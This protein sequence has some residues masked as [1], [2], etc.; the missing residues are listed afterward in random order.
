MKNKKK[1]SLF[2]LFLGILFIPLPSF[3][4]DV[5]VDEKLS[6]PPMINEEINIHGKIYEFLTNDPIQRLS[7]PFENGKVQ[8]FLIFLAGLAG[9]SIFVWYF[10]RFI[11][12]RDLLPGLL[13]RER[14]NKEN[15]ISLLILSISYAISFPIITFVWFTLYSALIFFLSSDMPYNLIMFV[16]MALIG[17]IRITSYFKEELAKDVGKAIPFS[18][19]GI[20]LTQG[21]LFTNPNFV[22]LDAIHAVL[23]EFQNKIPEIIVAVLVISV[24]EAMLRA[25]Y[26]ATFY[27]RGHHK[28]NLEGDKMMEKTWTE[29]HIKTDP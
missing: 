2:L 20:F 23:I 8:D 14:K 19:L 10:Y 26:I 5:P 4:Q 24:F 6:N 21:D 3:A 12:K 1:I 15:K 17:V 28:K 9:F 22:N 16:S 18:M 27:L 7:E 25:S 29:K 13:M 11:S